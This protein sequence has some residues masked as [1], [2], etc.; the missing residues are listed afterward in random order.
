MTESPTES[1]GVYLQLE[2]HDRYHVGDL[3]S[4]EDGR[5]SPIAMGRLMYAVAHEMTDLALHPEKLE[6]TDD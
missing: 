3:P 1:R 6:A 2:G 5:V 4:T